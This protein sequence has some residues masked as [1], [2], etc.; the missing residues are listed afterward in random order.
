MNNDDT[1]ILA[2]AYDQINNSINMKQKQTLITTTVA[3]DWKDIEGLCKEFETALKKF[4][5]HM[6][7]DPDMEG[8]DTYGFILSNRKL[9]KK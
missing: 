4:G 5:I 3:A 9:T 7:Q 2:E 6:V 1:K 8:S